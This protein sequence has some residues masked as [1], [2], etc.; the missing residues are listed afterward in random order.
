[1][2]ETFIVI[3]GDGRELAAVNRSELLR[4]LFEQV[5]TPDAMVRSSSSNVWIRLS[6]LVDPGAHPTD[7]PAAKPGPPTIS[8]PE[9]VP[10]PATTAPESARSSGTESHQPN[11]QV[12]GTD[13]S[14]KKVPP[15]GWP[16]FA[17]PIG[18]LLLLFL[19]TE[20]WKG[21]RSDAAG[22]VG[23]LMGYFGVPLVLYMV[24]RKWLGRLASTLAC[25][26]GLVLLGV[27]AAVAIPF[28]LGKRNEARQS[29]SQA[30][31][32][33]TRQSTPVLDLNAMA[34]FVSTEVRDNWSKIQ[35]RDVRLWNSTTDSLTVAVGVWDFQAG[36]YAIPEKGLEQYVAGARTQATKITWDAKGPTRVTTV[37]GAPGFRADFDHRAGKNLASG[38]IFFTALPIGE[39]EPKRMIML[40]VI[41]EGNRESWRLEEVERAFNSVRFRN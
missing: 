9:P 39:A 25:G 2:E 12:P 31:L 34:P 8:P 10:A 14:P 33:T 36:Y 16:D 19:S 24:L 23:Y 7:S 35:L 13:P 3:A 30:A 17:I 5:I 38:S 29:K 6:D 4:L 27:G 18:L 15:Y 20:G 1:M 22:L 32:Q 26:G 40:Q 28:L 21:V 41:A 11:H 37:G